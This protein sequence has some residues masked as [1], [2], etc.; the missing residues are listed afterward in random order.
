MNLSNFS[1]LY[2]D[3][4]TRQEYYSGKTLSD[5]DMYT[6]QELGML[7]IFDLKSSDL[8]Q[9]FTISKEVMEYRNK[10]FL[11]MMENPSLTSTLNKLVPIL[12]DITEL[13]RL[14]SDSRD[15]EDYLLRSNLSKDAPSSNAFEISIERS[16]R[17][18]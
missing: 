3:E 18:L 2:P 5:I 7:E 12:T 9:Y 15:G 4:K 8:S 1:L 14:E 17:K 10:T 13:R 11:D 16:P 6:L